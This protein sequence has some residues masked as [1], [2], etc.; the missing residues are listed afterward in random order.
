MKISNIQPIIVNGY[1]FNQYQF[2]KTLTDHYYES[3]F[4]F[5]MKKSGSLNTMIISYNISY[6]VGENGDDS[7]VLIPSD[8]PKYYTIHFQGEEPTE[9][10]VSYDSSCRFDFE[11]GGFDADMV[12]L[13]EFLRDYDSHT[14][15]F[16]MNYGYK[17][18]LDMEKDS[19]R[20]YPLN[21][22][23]LSAIDNLRLN[24]MY[25]FWI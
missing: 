23:A 8:D 25:E 2:K 20:R 5:R 12:S 4:R 3:G 13:A 7:S 9:I 6:T 10:L 1:V 18:V 17:P 11:S 22:C 21:K 24:N 15:T 19:R 14:K 16:L